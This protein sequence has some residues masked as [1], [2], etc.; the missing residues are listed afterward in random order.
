MIN[1]IIER[2]KKLLEYVE[3]YNLMSPFPIY[4]TEY[5]S[6]IKKHINK[7]EKID[8]YD[9]LPVVAC[10]YCKSLHIINDEEENDVC[11][12]CGAVNNVEIYTDIYNYHEK[13]KV[14]EKC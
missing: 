4:D 3:Y 5:V 1:E 14:N 9:K 13:T 12:R 2:F 10:K 7:M 6:E 11:M 8:E